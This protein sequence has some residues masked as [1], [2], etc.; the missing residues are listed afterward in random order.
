MDYLEEYQQNYEDVFFVEESNTSKIFRGYNKVYQRDVCLKIIDKK[1][2]ELGDFD[3]LLEQIKR[4]EEITKLCKSEYI[5]NFYQKFETNNSIIFE[6]EYCETDLMEYIKENGELRNNPEFFK[7]LIIILAKVLKMLQSK[8]I[9]HRDIKP[10]NIFL[11]NEEDLNSIKLGDFGCSIFIKDNTSDPIGTILYSAPEI[12]QNFE[13]DEKCDLWSLGVTLYQLYFFS[14]P[15]GTDVTTDIIMEAITDPENNF[16]FKKTNIPSIDFLF[17]KLLK[18]EPEERMTYP[19]FFNYVLNNNF[20]KNIEEI[21]EI[22]NNQIEGEDPNEDNSN[23]SFNEEKQEKDIVNKIYGFAKGNHF[24]DIMNFPNGS[25]EINPKYNNIIY[26]DENQNYKKKV[27]TDSD[28]FERNTPG[29]FIL[30]TSEISLIMVI[31]EIVKQIKKDKRITFNLI[32]T[33]SKFQKVMDLVNQNKDFENCIQNL[34]IYCMKIKDY[35][36]YNQIYPKLHNDIYNR[37][38][39]VIDFI[40]RSALKDIKAYP[41]TKLITLADYQDK[42]KERHFKVSQF[43]GDLT[44]ESYQQY[45]KEM[46]KLINLEVENNELYGTQKAVFKGF[47]SFDIKEDIDTLDKL[48]IQEYTKNTFYGDLNKWLM[49]SKMNFYEPVAYFTTRLMFSLNK[50]AK[51]NDKFCKEN[52]KPIYRGIKIPYTCLLPYERAKGKIILLSAFTSTSED[53]NKAK[54][55]AGR[56]NPKKLYKNSL[57][58]SVIFYIT[59]IYENDWVS[60]GINIQD[61]AQFKKEKEYLFQ[62]FTFYFVKNVK[63]DINK[64]TADIDLETIGKYEILEEK[65][66]Y[67]NEVNYDEIENVVRI[68]K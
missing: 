67:G 8:G 4:E 39:Q 6:L 62:P 23:E 1:Q 28:K 21:K 34:C 64:Y 7:N 40:K 19:E 24:P 47:L 33:G 32:S 10:Q 9:M 27:F 52:K 61:V 51:K 2:L 63:I 42:Y 25:T 58:F 66:K 50:Y 3:F 48:I 41:L 36:H 65:I 17:E 14:L 31:D 15:Y 55:F 20:M 5:V 29:A 35:L 44:P 22:I 37:P 30:C 49:N 53:D 38:N 43:Y 13:Y 59:N 45:L 54:V 60:N 56:R 68:K 46:K 57:H 18:I 16:K 11:K 12:I 26:Y